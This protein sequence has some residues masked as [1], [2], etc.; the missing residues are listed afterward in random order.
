LSS[1]GILTIGSI[2]DCAF[3]VVMLLFL[4]ASI[5]ALTLLFLLLPQRFRDD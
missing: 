3:A 1:P 2:Q 4:F 5:F